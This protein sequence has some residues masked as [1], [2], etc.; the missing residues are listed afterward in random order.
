VYHG[1]YIGVCWV[2]T[3]GVHRGACRHIRVYKGRHAGIYTT[4]VRREG[5]SAQSPP[6]SFGRERDNDAQSPPGSF[7]EEK[8]NDAQ[9]PPGSFGREGGMM[10]RVLPV[11]LGEEKE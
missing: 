6:G 11:P 9:S 7:D 5:N 10:R 2:C 3:T 1:V 4:R 8:D